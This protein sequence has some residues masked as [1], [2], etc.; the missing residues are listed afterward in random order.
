SRDAFDVARGLGERPCDVGRH[1]PSGLFQFVL[2]HFERSADAVQLP[3]KT[4]EGAIAIAP[5]QVD[6]RTHTPIEPR[7]ALARTVHESVHRTSVACVDDPEHGQFRRSCGA[8][9]YVVSA[10]RRTWEVRLKPDTTKALAAVANRVSA[11]VLRFD[12]HE[13]NRGAPDAG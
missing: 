10:F 6:D 13:T 12:R 9:T 2:R 7:I 4:P 5:D 8:L 11:S 1:S 3:R